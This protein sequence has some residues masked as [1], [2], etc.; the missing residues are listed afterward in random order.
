MVIKEE[1]NNGAL[2]K[3][4]N[5]KTAYDKRVVTTNKYVKKVSTLKA[6]LDSL[7]VDYSQSNLVNLTNE[8]YLLTMDYRTALEDLTTS[9]KKE[10]ELLDK[11]N[12][13]TKA[14]EVAKI[15][16]NKLSELP[17][18][19]KQTIEYLTTEWTKSD[20]ALKEHLK[21]EFTALGMD[22]FYKQYSSPKYSF[23]RRG[24]EEDFKKVNGKNAKDLITDL[25]NRVT[26]VVGSITDLSDIQ[27]KGNSLNGFVSGEQGRCRIET[28]VAGG[29]NIQKL[30]YRVLVHKITS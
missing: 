22:A 27:F 18:C 9:Q 19:F 5:A 28:I 14:Y 29:Y 11:Y 26:K 2:T 8:Q 30:H 20:I 6:K 16:E 17:E 1:T 13:A 23:Y 12:K 21:N 4:E 10:Q 24:T 3:M 7:G 25:I 15:K